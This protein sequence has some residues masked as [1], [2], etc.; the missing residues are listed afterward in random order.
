MA[1]EY[2]TGRRV[3]PAL[4]ALQAP[5]AMLVPHRIDRHGATT[6]PRARTRTQLAPFSTRSLARELSRRLLRP[7]RA[8]ARMAR[9]GFYGTTPR[10]V[11]LLLVAGLGVAVLAAAVQ[12]ESGALACT[13]GPL[14]L[15]ALGGEVSSRQVA[16]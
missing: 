13:L 10:A 2:P 14:A 3:E 15:V 9:V 1:R 8:A 11:R 16:S 7:V 5:A 6:M 4:I 12:R